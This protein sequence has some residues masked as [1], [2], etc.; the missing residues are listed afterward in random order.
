MPH[1]FEQQYDDKLWHTLFVSLENV[2]EFASM[3][4]IRIGIETN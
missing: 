2:F 3:L 1:A 4:G